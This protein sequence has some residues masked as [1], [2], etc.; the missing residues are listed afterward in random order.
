MGLYNK[1][2]E[3]LTELEIYEENSK[4]EDLAL[5]LTHIAEEYTEK[6]DL[7]GY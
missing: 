7:E 5:Q 4:I 3:L 2:Y 1:I 6:N